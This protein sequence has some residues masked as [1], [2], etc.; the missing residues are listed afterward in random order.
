MAYVSKAVIISKTGDNAFKTIVRI[1]DGAITMYHSSVKSG[2]GPFC[3]PGIQDSHVIW[4]K[5]AS[6]SNKRTA[7]LKNVEMKTETMTAV[8][9]AVTVQ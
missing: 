8:I 9:S 1:K 5:L 7:V 3:T 4:D 6:A 2:N